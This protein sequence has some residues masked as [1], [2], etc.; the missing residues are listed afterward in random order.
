VFIG[1]AD[2]VERW[3]S[4]ERWYVASEDEKVQHLRDLVGADALHPIVNA[5]GK[6]VYVNRTD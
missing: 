4:P 6:T 1:D 5:G 3:Q 2:F